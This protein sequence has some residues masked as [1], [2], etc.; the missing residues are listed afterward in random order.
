MKPRRARFLLFLLLAAVLILGLVRLRFDVDVL[1]LL[2]ADLPAVRG[3]QLYEENFSTARELIIALHAPDAAGAENAARS[4]ADALQRAPSLA[5]QATWQPPW[6]EHPGQTA[7]LAAYLWFNQP[8]A[9]FG[10]LTNRLAPD[11]LPSI[12][13]R[14]RAR[15]TT[16]LSAEEISRASY[17]PYGLLEL[18]KATG[19]TG[20]SFQQGTEAFASPDGTLRLIFVQAVSDIGN[21]R[22]AA[23]WLQQVQATVEKW[24]AANKIPEDVS[25]DFTGGPAFAAEIGASMERN[26]RYSVIG[27]LIIVAALFWWAHRRFRPLLWLLTLLAL[28]LIGTLASGGLIF[29][30]INV[31][32]MGFAAMLLGLA[33]D[34]GLVLYQEAQAA[35]TANARSIRH[36]LAPGILWSAVT[37]AGAFCVLSL[38]GLPGL[39]QLGWLVAIGVVLAAVVML[40]FFL[41]PLVRSAAFHRTRPTADTPPSPELQIPSPMLLRPGNLWLATAALLVAC[42]AVL[43]HRFPALDHSTSALRPRHIRAYDVSDQIKAALDQKSEPLWVLATGAS[44]T[45][46]AS[47][48]DQTSTVLA[49][50]ISNGTIRSFTLPTTLCPRPNFQRANRSTA[51]ALCDLRGAL[52]AA[53]VEHGF[54]SNS[55]ALTDT[56]LNT[57]RQAANSVQTFYPTN[58]A[59]QWILQ[60]VFAR[61]TNE[62]VALGLIYP[63]EPNPPLAPVQR[64][65]PSGVILSGWETLGGAVLGVVKKDFVRVLVPMG[66]LV[67]LSLWLAFRSFIGVLLSLA[68]LGLSLLMLLTVMR[69]AHWDWNLMNMTAIPLLLGAGIDYGIHMQ[70]GLRRHGGDIAA[71]RRTVGRALL[72]CAGTTIAGFGSLSWS[73]NTGLASLGRICATGVA[74]CYATAV[75]LLPVWWKSLNR[76][77]TA[78]VISQPSTLYRTWLWRLCL[79]L[80]RTLPVRVTEKFSRMLASAYWRMNRPRREAVIENLMPL[81]SHDRAAAETGSRRLYEN[82]AIKLTDLWRYENGL[83]IDH[84]FAALEGWEHYQ[85][86]HAQNRGVLVVTPHLGNWEFGGPILTQRGISLLVVTLVEPSP[87]LT[88]LRKASRARWN[89]ETL[90]IGYDPFASVEVIRRLEAGATVALLMDRPPA[91][92]MVSVE[93]LGRPFHASVAAA[94]FARASGCAIL[95]V[96]LPRGKRGY[97]AR[98]EPAIQYDRAALRDREARRQLTQQIMRAFEPVIRQNPDQWYHFVPVWP[99]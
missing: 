52:T 55:M 9:I 67:L 60:K 68:A 57:W 12:L 39:A 59:S 94:E 45:Q 14:T 98:I 93:F 56:L 74:C 25:V 87:G 90:V 89:I 35:P 81:F 3:L 99:K 2:P 72:L 47:E 38:G 32:S 44:T 51:R 69:L 75:L 88:E 91:R 1:N 28:I 71:T 61:S 42:V 46:V 30:T 54:T 70:L 6:Q 23:Q 27:T 64:Q 84:L 49:S 58:T 43:W 36:A 50:Q 24:R 22:T 63:T 29:G 95:P 76:G 15:L 4:L 92:S 66:L 40:R 7:E 19:K 33:V 80:T 73:T 34:Y 86:A 8:P 10:Q 48:L 17:D 97:A 41:P 26:I 85:A 21:Y 37:T 79:A 31:V 13:E 82:F 53:A 83:P 20:T 18:P 65:L 62:C 78:G 11:K 96:Y 77:A 16:S 5:R